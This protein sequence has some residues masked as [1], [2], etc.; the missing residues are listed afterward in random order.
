MSSST[1][2]E[3]N[4]RVA[5]RNITVDHLIAAAQRILDPYSFE[6][7]EVAWWSVYEIGQ[8]LCDKF[9]DVPG[10]AS[11]V[12][13]ASRVHRRRRLPYPQPEGRPGHER[14]DAGRL[15]SGMETGGRPA[16]AMRARPSSQLLGGT[17]GHRQGAD[18]LRPRMGQDD[19]CAAE[20]SRRSRRRGR[21]SGRNAELFRQARPIHRRHGDPLH[22]HPSS[23]PTRRHQHLAK[24]FPIGMRFHS[25]PVIRLA[26]AKPVSPRPRRQGGR[27]LAHF[28]FRDRGD[29]SG[30]ASSHASG[31]CAT[32]LPILR[33]LPSANTRPQIADIDSVIDVRAMFQQAH[34]ELDLEAMPAFLLPPQKAAT[35][36]ATTRK[37]S[38]PTSR[39]T[40]HLRHARHRSR[41]GLHG[42]GATR[43]VCRTHPAARC[44]RRPNNILRQTHVTR[45][46]RLEAASQVRRSPSVL[47]VHLAI[48]RHNSLQFQLHPQ[49]PVVVL[50]Q[51]ATSRCLCY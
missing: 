12:A 20:I 27:P 29:P 35:G 51:R 5:N 16:R 8:R 46:A 7:K 33:S 19:Q 23:P 40:R 32:F 44:L 3:S 13:F 14:L 31:R 10:G 9:D 15:Q 30:T 50:T 36:F 17:P 34:R 37:C 11:R 49:Y 18:R 4:E 21:R 45:L 1:E 38:A 48:R 39:R 41:P 43:S 6:V 25:A 24:G 2:L 47:Y 22:A 26:D 28:R 42:G